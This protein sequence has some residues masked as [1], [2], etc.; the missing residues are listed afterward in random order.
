MSA[1]GPRTHFRCVGSDDRCGSGQSVFLIGVPGTRLPRARARRAREGPP[2]DRACGHFRVD[3]ASRGPAVPSTSG[4]QDATGRIRLKRR[5]S[6]AVAIARRYDMARPCSAWGPAPPSLLPS[7][8]VAPPR[9]R[10]G[11]PRAGQGRRLKEGDGATRRRVA[12]LR[13]VTPG[14]AA[15]RKAP[16]ARRRPAPFRSTQRRAGQPR[17]PRQTPDRVLSTL[18]AA[19]RPSGRP[20]KSRRGSAA[21]RWAARRCRPAPRSL[22]EESRDVGDAWPASASACL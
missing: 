14:D 15:A 1:A 21:R 16:A 10:R 4:S 12:R 6:Q 22:H 3:R 18:R 13:R 17:H 9:E 2:V 7:R 8:A 11:S 19:A 20:S 5:R